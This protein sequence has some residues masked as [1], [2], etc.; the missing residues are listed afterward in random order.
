MTKIVVAK[1]DLE[2]GTEIDAADLV[3]KAYPTADLPKGVKKDPKELVGRV[4]VSLATQDLPIAERLLAPPGTS[5]GIIGQIPPGMRAV[6]VEVNASSG[7]GGLILPNSH[8]DV[9]ATLRTPDGEMA[10]TIV[11]DVVVRA[12]NGKMSR[13]RS[14][15]ETNPNASSTSGY[16]LAREREREQNATKTVTLIVTP[17][18]AAKIELA[19]SNGR[20]R[21]VLR[22]A[23]DTTL[24]KDTPAVKLNDLTGAPAAQEPEK[25]QGP[26]AMDKFLAYMAEAAKNAKPAAAPAP[27]QLSIPIFRGGKQDTMVF[28]R[29]GGVET[30]LHT[31]TPTPPTTHPSEA[32][33][34][35]QESAGGWKPADSGAGP[36][37]KDNDKERDP[38]R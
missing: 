22:S 10:R 3:L 2:P 38:F 9:I 35:G 26:S 24:A 21:L 37:P 28:E 30:P 29:K 16:A 4:L 17:G 6:A 15:E 25:P 31:G 14:F 34:S 36:A 33:A 5:A 13:D 12:V 20:L 32:T 7:V 8:V 19:G 11:S 23:N 27:E 1:H 18:D